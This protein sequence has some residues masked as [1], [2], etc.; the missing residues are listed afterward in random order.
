MTRSSLARLC[1][2]LTFTVMSAPFGALFAA[3]LEA[4]ADAASSSITF[5]AYTKLFDAEGSFK[6]IKTSGTIDSENLAA[7]RPTISI[8]T[9]T[10]DTASSARDKHLRTEDFF[11]VDKYPTATFVVTKIEA[12]EG[13]QYLVSGDMTIRDVT[14]KITVPAT[15]TRGTLK[16]GEKTLRVQAKFPVKWKEYGMPWSGAFYAPEIKEV[17]DVKVDLA[18]VD[19]S[20]PTPT[21]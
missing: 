11:F 2:A 6:G 7:S 15:I 14:K 19:K 3:P 12:K 16:S 13:D 20:V 8:D 4:N 5:T 21:P 1:A 18:F 10:I 9:R 17:I